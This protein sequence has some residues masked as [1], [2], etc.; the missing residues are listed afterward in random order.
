MMA[1]LGTAFCYACGTT[2]VQQPS[3]EIVET[4]SDLPIGTRVLLLAP[5]IRGK[6]SGF[7]EAMRV[8]QQAGL[9]RIRIN[10]QLYEV[11]SPPTGADAE[12]STL[13]AVVD[14]FILKED[15]ISR[16]Q[17]AVRSAIELSDGLV[18][19]SYWLPDS[20]T[21]PDDPSAWQ[22]QLFSTRYSCLE[23]GVSYAEI[24]PRTFSFNSPH[25]ACAHCRGTGLESSASEDSPGKDGKSKTKSREEE[26]NIP[27][28][29]SEQESCTQCHGS[30]LR[31]E[32][33]AI[34]IDSRN[35]H[36]LASMSIEACMQWMAQLTFPAEKQPIAAPIVDNVLHRLRFLCEV[37]LDYL[38]LAR[39]ADTLSGGELQRVRLATSIGSG[40]LGVCYVLDEPS[41]GLHPRDNA[42][43][44]GSLR[45][46]QQ[47]GNTLV[48]VE[49]DEAIM[50]EA[51]LLI[52]MGPGA[53][54]AGGRILASGTPQDL[55]SHPESVTAKYLSGQTTVA[56]NCR[57]KVD[58][59]RCLQLSNV[60]ANNL[61]H[62]TV[63]IPFGCFVGITGV[64]GS[65]KSS[66]INDC[67]VPAAAKALGWPGARDCSKGELKG[68]EFLDRLVAVDQ[69]PIGRSPRSTPATYCGIYDEIRKVYATTRDAKQRG[70]NAQRFSFNTGIGRCDDCQGQGR[71]KLEMS[72]LADLSIVCPTC[73]GRRFNRQTLQ[74]KYR[75]QSIA[76][77]LSMDVSTAREFFANFIKIFRVLD[78][79]ER[80]GLGYLS[81]GQPST[82]VSGGE[83]QRI[84]LATELA[85]ADTGKTL[86]VL[87]E[88]TSG[89][90]FEDVRR[91]IDVVQGLVDKG[92]TVVVIEHNLDV[93]AS[94][95][96]LID[97]GPEGESGEAKWYALEHHKRSPD[98]RQATPGLGFVNE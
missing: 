15:S 95:D 59:A 25:G 62:V 28:W 19:I 5:M 72:F 47:Q 51:D 41:I 66:L 88:P 80:V 29:Q 55:S 74:V 85:T 79:L 63:E 27:S 87:D 44:I 48:V 38:T 97:L 11:D 12:R 18:S 93:I 58:F 20:D 33:L 92:N 57:R 46:L 94:C 10:R 56:T 84:K 34:K 52:D 40:L 83:A 82:T 81:L 50:R 98:A 54:K 77:C 24:E 86:Y 64:S 23:C 32:S 43:L 69:R 61:K 96:W 60:H 8:I 6:R 90:H 35:I 39:S 71:Q 26:P 91:L 9:V 30:R 3:S 89:L 16:I 73:Q 2:I 49:H 37:G 31:P 67:L 65:G 42:R 45:G 13:E 22:E 36:D 68:I 76:D 75:D 14:R 70:Y 1:R 7:R 4:I 78:C 17:D 53:G 21:P